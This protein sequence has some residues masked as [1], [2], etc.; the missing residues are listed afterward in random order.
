V[1]KTPER[2]VVHVLED[3]E[4]TGSRRAWPTEHHERFEV[5]R[6]GDLATYLVKRRR[7]TCDL[8]VGAKVNEKRIN[9]ERRTLTLQ[10][11]TSLNQHLPVRR[12]L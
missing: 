6:L 2:K 9:K 8:A 10:G 3:L 12:R 7:E 11:T 4:T 5:R 1:R